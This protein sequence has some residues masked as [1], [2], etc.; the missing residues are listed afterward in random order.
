MR[1]DALL[2]AIALIAAPAGAQDAPPQQGRIW[3]G[4]LGKEAI[5]ACFFEERPGTGLFYADADLEPVRLEAE[6]DSAPDILREMKRFDRP[7]GA[8][9]TISIAGDRLTGVWRNGAGRQAIRLAAQAVVYPEYGS[10]CESEAFLGPVLTGGTVQSSRAS[11]NGTAYTVLEYTGPQRS[12]LAEYGVTAFQ[13][14]P[15]RPGDRAINR[16]LAAAI[17]DGTARHEAGQCLAGSL[18]WSSG[19]GDYGKSLQPTLITPRWLGVSFTGSSF[20]G[21]AHPN[22]FITAQVFDRNS[23][24][25]VDPAVWFKPGALT[26]YDWEHEPGEMR[27]IAGLSKALAQALLKRL[28]PHEEGDECGSIVGEGQFTWNIGLT[29]EG[30]VF[31]PQL[32]H[33]IFACTEEVTLPWKDARPFLSAE[34]R[35]V[36]ESLR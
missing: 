32:P 24:A 21:G 35:A 19:L 27:P 4:T 3:K 14:D 1:A 17:P 20:C 12:G 10:S 34:G 28:P 15:V 16:T 8:V 7:S 23:G 11:L 22:H 6:S 2:A 13:L 33:V 25:Q 30:P 36:M 9:W 18:S 5:T 26:F 31:V 29:R